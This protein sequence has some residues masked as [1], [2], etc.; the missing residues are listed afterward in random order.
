VVYRLFVSPVVGGH[1][2]GLLTRPLFGVGLGSRLR[3]V[4]H[5]PLVPGHVA[6]FAVLLAA[7]AAVAVWSSLRMRATPMPALPALPTAPTAPTTP[8]SPKAS[9]ASTASAGS[10]GNTAPPAMPAALAKAMR[11]L[12]FGTVLAAAVLPLATGL[13]LAT[14]TLWSLLERRHLQ[15]LTAQ[16]AAGAPAAAA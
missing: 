15:R 3:D 13:Y 1:A 11:L 2:N 7:V 8:T 10:A 12:P 16:P 9:T 4:L 14:T 5:A 6:V